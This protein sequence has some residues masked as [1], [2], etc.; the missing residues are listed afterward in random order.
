VLN[1]KI[2]LSD[3][4]YGHIVRQKAI[5][6][7]LH[8]YSNRQV[9]F[10]L[11]T[12]NH[13]KAAKDIFGKGNFVNKYNNISWQKLGSGSPELEKIKKHYKNYDLKSAEFISKEKDL[14]EFDFLIS[15]FVYEAFLLGKKN[16]IPSFGVAHF[17]WDWFFSKLYPPTI[18]SKVMN[19]F[20]NFANKADKI[21]FPLFTPVEILKHYKNSVQVPLIVREKNNLGTINIKNS[22]FKILIIDSGSNLL[23]LHIEKSL[24]NL[25]NLKD[26]QFFLANDYHSDFENIK[27]IPKSHLM[28][29]YIESMDLVIARAGFN[30]IS[31][32]IACRT[33]MLLIGEAMNPEI[34]ENI[35]NLKNQ[36]LASF[37]SID[38]FRLGLH[39]FL[40]IFLKN[41][42]NSLK[43]NMLNHELPIN[44]AEVIAKDILN[45]IN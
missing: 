33:P 42:F 31:E 27:N 10:T 28:M 13:L 15:D 9:D 34:N 14:S 19:L 38:E 20:F 8:D 22:N 45:Y 3:E 41:E 32:C 1:Y 39:S 2:Y 44:G 4:G 21:Y 43:T 26:I 12:Q 40:P 18:N 7:K 37:V 35:I 25:A 29:D 23:K 5:L 16:K 30:T 36:G 17:T 24:E 6:E 11:Q